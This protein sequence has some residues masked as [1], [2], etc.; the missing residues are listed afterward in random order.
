[1]SADWNANVGLALLVGLFGLLTMVGSGSCAANGTLKTRP[2]KAPPTTA[3]SSPTNIFPAGSRISAW[4]TSY[5]PRLLSR[6]PAWLE[7]VNTSPVLTE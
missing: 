3:G 6:K 4:T 5:A 7:K 2:L 1:M